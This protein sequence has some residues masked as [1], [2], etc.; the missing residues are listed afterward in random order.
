MCRYALSSYL[1][2]YSY[3][4]SLKVTVA[5]NIERNNSSISVKKFNQM[6]WAFIKVNFKVSQLQ[7]WQKTQ[8]EYNP[9]FERKRGFSPGPTIKQSTDYAKIINGRNL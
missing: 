1:F 4:L 6:N 3:F 5:D 9:M 2:K 8:A 7:T